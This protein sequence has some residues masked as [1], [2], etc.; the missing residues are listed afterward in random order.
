MYDYHFNH[1]SPH[2]CEFLILHILFSFRLVTELSACLTTLLAEVVLSCLV[3]KE[4]GTPN[5]PLVSSCYNQS[6]S[7]MSKCDDVTKKI[8]KLMGNGTYDV[9][10]PVH[11]ILTCTKCA[12]MYSIMI[13]FHC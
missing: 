7:V 11:V 3:A 1:C 5:D 9:F 10:R 13:A 8:I 2:K 12:E 4:T 6:V